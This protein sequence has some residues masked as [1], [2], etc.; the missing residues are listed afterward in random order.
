MKFT[1][2]YWNI[3]EGVT[4]YNA[5]EICDANVGDSTL[6]V[7]AACKPV[8]APGRHAEFPAAHVH[9][10]FPDG[11]CDSSAGMPLRRRFRQRS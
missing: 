1:D 8:S 5:V 11:R 4:L 9:F 2:G 3:R 6:T 7:Y 10:Q